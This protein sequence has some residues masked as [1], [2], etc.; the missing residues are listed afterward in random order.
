MS[1]QVF[2][3]HVREHEPIHAATLLRGAYKKTPQDFPELTPD[4]LLVKQF[5]SDAYVELA[6]KRLVPIAAVPAGIVLGAI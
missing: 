6:N 3:I 5:G 4:E 1:D 2:N